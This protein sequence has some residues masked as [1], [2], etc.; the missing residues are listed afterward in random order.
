MR[1]LTAVWPHGPDSER[2]PTSRDV[3]GPH[4]QADH[5]FLG[6]GWPLTACTDH[7]QQVHTDKV[8][9]DMA[10]IGLRKALQNGERGLDAGW[11][12]KSAAETAHM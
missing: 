11:L 7:M 5:S 3:D 10:W 12:L 4:A 8:M 2:E 6:T 9:N 1:P